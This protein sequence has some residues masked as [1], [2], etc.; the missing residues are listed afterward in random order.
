VVNRIEESKP[1]A[2]PTGKA[3]TVWRLVLPL[4]GLLDL[5]AKLA[6]L[7][8]NLQTQGYLCKFQ[9]AKLTRP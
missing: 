5:Y 1:P 4:S 9:V 8:G 7:V 2:P 6:Q 3:L